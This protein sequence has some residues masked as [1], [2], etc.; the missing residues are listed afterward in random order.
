[1]RIKTFTLMLLALFVSA[2]SFAQKPTAPIEKQFLA[3]RP[4]MVQKGMTLPGQMAMSNKVTA[5]P[6]F[7][8]MNQ[9]GVVVPP[10]GGDVLY[11]TLSGKHSRLSSGKLERTVKVIFDGDDVY[12]S[13]LSYFCPDAFVKGS[14]NR[15]VWSF[16]PLQYMGD[17]SFS[18]GDASLFMS[19]NPQS[20]GFTATLNEDETVFTFPSYVC[21]YYAIGQESGLTAYWSPNTTL[22]LIEGEVDLPVEAPTDLVTEQ[23]SLS[24]TSE[25][26]G[27]P[28]I[29]R[30]VKLGF[31][32]DEVYLQGISEDLP[33]AWIKGTME[34]DIVT[35]KTGQ[36]LGAYS[37]AYNLW[38]LG[39]DWTNDCPKDVQFFYD[40]EAQKFTADEYL[41]SIKKED[42]RN[43]C[44]E[45]NA[46]V[47]ISKVVEKPG[48]PANPTISNMQFTPQM[49][50]LEFTVNV[51]DI[52]GNGMLPEKLFFKLYY[53]DVV[54]TEGEVTFSKDY[55][56][57]LE[58]DLT[59]IPYTIDNKEITNSKVALLMDHADW[60]EV[61]LQA[62]YKGGGESHE[63]K[64]AWY[65]INWPIVTTLPEGLT[66]LNHDF[67]GTTYESGED[68]PFTSTLNIAK[69]GDDL[70]IQGFGADA[71]VS[72]TWVKGT[73]DEDGVYVFK[74]GQDLGS[75]SSYRLFLVGVGEEGIDDFK[76][77]VDTENGVYKFLNPVLLNVFYTDKSYYYTYYNEDCTITLKGESD[78]PVVAPEG[79]V[80]A[81]YT[82]KG[83]DYF[84]EEGE[85]SIVTHTVKLGFD[86]NDV[87]AQG[88]SLTLP[89]AWVKGTLD[90]NSISFRT[91]QALGTYRDYDLWFVGLDDET[92]KV[93]NY[94]CSYDAKNG[95]ITAPEG[96]LMGV[97]I[98]KASINASLFE[99]YKD[100]TITK[101]TEKAATPANP[102][103]GNM[104]YTPYGSIFNYDLTG[105]D[106]NGEGLLSSKLYFKLYSKDNEGTQSVITFTP[107]LYEK[108]ESAMEEVP[109]TFTDN[110]DFYEGS[111]F[112]NMS[113]Y[114]WKQIGMQSIYKG[115]GET[116]ESEIV[117]Y[118]LVLPYIAPEPDSTVVASSYIFKGT[119]TESD[120]TPEFEMTVNIVNDGDKLYIQG[121]EPIDEDQ[122]AWIVGI[123]GEDNVYTFP[124]GAYM[125]LY[126]INERSGLYL[127]AIGFDDAT[128]KVCDI[129]IKYDSEA[130]TYTLLTGLVVNAEYT[131]RLYYLDF[132]NAG[133]TFT[134]VPAGIEKVSV[135]TESVNA[136]AFNISGQ[137]VNN[138]FKGLVIKNGKKFFVK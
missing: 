89:E 12:I 82:F 105:V 34:N 117:W 35:F 3:Q 9:I 42:Y 115:G 8:P 33:N 65:T 112:L 66:V 90:G 106:I 39:Y 83:T 99:L 95:V 11:Y 21:E 67:E 25:F 78:D 13:G 32:G 47:T 45:V 57:A 74:S 53:K 30:L 135:D 49:D 29:S 1:M 85:D 2:L 71:G 23:Y 120:G 92:G 43:A 63:S 55:Y 28:S 94:V 126:M 119:K 132:F 46:D 69:S 86:G 44:F 38:F 52:E 20:A 80:T 103:I 111:L 130:N 41:I 88:L 16:E 6:K 22:T 10:A 77:G 118:D 101:I 70:Y 17:F 27:N 73:K 97:N 7:A 124:Q 59:E 36:L 96:M 58:N 100:V 64:I 51:S 116:H 68:V 136:P 26:E 131:D 107:D 93:T 15:D 129:K 128:E 19:G 113:I 60:T 54:G 109:A 114:S 125:G 4:S 18:D 40:R 79:L 37:A 134:Q 87:Y 108:L 75:T 104:E 48:I 98:Y 84:A 5:T 31:Y 121:I 137:R 76:L 138:S 24:A 56:T 91:G 81:E 127:F 50:N 122:N 102:I 72:E 62:I 110:Y 14:L 133:S 123:K 61:G